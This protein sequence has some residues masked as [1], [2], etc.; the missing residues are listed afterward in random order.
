[1]FYQYVLGIRNIADVI[2][3]D[4]CQIKV[5]LR[6]RTLFIVFYESIDVREVL[7][8]VCKYYL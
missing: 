1:M 4:R 5:Y 3:D 2:S 8:S 7:S 6:M